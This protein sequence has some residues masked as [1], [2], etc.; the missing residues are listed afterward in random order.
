MSA[1]FSFQ[2]YFL[3]V[4][5]GC[6]LSKDQ[7]FYKALIGSGHLNV[8]LHITDGLTRRTKDKS[9]FE[10]GVVKVGVKAAFFKK[11]LMRALF[12]DVA[13]VHY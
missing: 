10:L 2:E 9:M 6:F 5:Q 8:G 1:V 3:S 4:R 11:F 7:V 12:D 13:L